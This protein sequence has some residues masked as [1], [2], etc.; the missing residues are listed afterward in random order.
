M[1]NKITI[2]TAFYNLGRGNWN[3]DG[4]KPFE[5]RSVDKYFEYFKLLSEIGND[6]IVYTSAEYVDRVK[7]CRGDKPTTVIEFDFM[8][9]FATELTAVRRVHSSEDFRSKIRPDLIN[10]P[11][12]WCAEYTLI[13]CFKSALLNNA[14]E[15]GLVNTE[16]VAW[17]DFGMCRST[18]TLSGVTEWAYDFDPT[19]INVFGFKE[20]T[21]DINIEHVIANNIVY[22]I[23]TYFV[24][25]KALCNSYWQLTKQYF[26]MLIAK[27]MIDDDQSLTAYICSNNLEL[28]AQ[29]RLPDNVWFDVFHLYNKLK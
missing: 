11:E 16:L 17:V 14:V 10:N 27:N 15:A 23:G 12:Y 4:S 6:M 26:D 18:A 21:A 20:I 2:V 13:N 1:D 19:K 28:Y 25:G 24:C 29:H 5:N 22:A 7:Q 8:T 9:K 3:L